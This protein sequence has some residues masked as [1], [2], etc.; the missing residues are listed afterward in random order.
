MCDFNG[1]DYKEIDLSDRKTS[2]GKVVEITPGLMGNARYVWEGAEL[3][4]ITLTETTTGDELTI[5]SDDAPYLIKWLIQE[6]GM[7]D[8][9]L[10]WDWLQHDY[11]GVE[12]PQ[13]D[14]PAKNDDAPF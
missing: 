1:L 14:T 6:L 8:A 3:K 5:S 10:L 4:A 12:R 13:V 11:I 2:Y 7:V 9:V